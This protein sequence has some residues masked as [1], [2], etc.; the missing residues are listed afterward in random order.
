MILYH[1]TTR[2]VAQEIKVHG[3]ESG[4]LAPTLSAAWMWGG[5][6]HGSWDASMLEPDLTD[7]AVVRFNLPP[8]AVY[9]YCKWEDGEYDCQE[10]PPEYVLS[11]YTRVPQRV[12]DQLNEMKTEIW[13]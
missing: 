1:G 9:K 2:D 4:A 7:V 12:R 3:L 8:G 13:I 10:I 11:V 6:M 5:S